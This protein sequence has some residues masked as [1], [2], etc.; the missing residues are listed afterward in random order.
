ML[1]FIVCG[2]IAFGSCWLLAK[3]MEL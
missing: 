1:S 2:I 3:V